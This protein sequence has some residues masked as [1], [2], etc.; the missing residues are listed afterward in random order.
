VL[1]GSYIHSGNKIA[2]LVALSARVEG[3][4]EASRNVAC[5]LLQC[6]IALDEAGVDAAVIEKKLKSLKTLLRQE[7]K[8]QC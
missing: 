8:Q 5:K 4:E 7:G 2:T 6:S 3:A 1:V